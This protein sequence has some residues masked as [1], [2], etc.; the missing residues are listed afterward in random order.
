MLN[1]KKFSC[2]FFLQKTLQLRDF[3]DYMACVWGNDVSVNSSQ[4]C[5][6]LSTPQVNEKEQ[7]KKISSLLTQFRYYILYYILFL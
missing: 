5:G 4:L 3:L 2:V 1:F 6:V 7:M